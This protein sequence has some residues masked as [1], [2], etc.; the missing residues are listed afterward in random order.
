MATQTTETRGALARCVEPI[1]DAEF[2]ADY[3]EQ[4]PLAV[5][6]AEEGRFDD[7]LS[8]ADVERLVCSGGLRHPAFRLVKEGGQ[9]ALRDYTTDLRWRPTPFTDTADPDR[10]AAAFEDGAT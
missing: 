4:K 9:V 1:D 7:L 5:P 3:W 8:V 6:R 10:V 2:L